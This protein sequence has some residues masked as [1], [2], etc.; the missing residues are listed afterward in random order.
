MC[1]TVNDFALLNYPYT[2]GEYTKYLMV[3]ISQPQYLKTHNVIFSL[4]VIKI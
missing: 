4:F 1:K 3:K 2:K